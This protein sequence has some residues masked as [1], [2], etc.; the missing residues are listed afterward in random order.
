M[1]QPGK[2]TRPSSREDYLELMRKVSNEFEPRIV[3]ENWGKRAT[4]FHKIHS[5]DNLT[6]KEFV[7]MHF[8]DNPYLLDKVLLSSTNGGYARR[9]STS[10]PLPPNQLET[11]TCTVMGYKTSVAK[12]TDPVVE[13]GE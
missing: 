7:E 5:I 1:N 10:S 6:R 13:V 4:I 8:P 2:K 9:I 3:P 12:D 11:F